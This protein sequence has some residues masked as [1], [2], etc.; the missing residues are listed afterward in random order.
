MAAASS[1]ERPKFV[2]RV[3]SFIPAGH[4]KALQQAFYNSAAAVLLVFVGG[5]ARAVYFVLEAFLKPLLWAVL[6]GTLLHPFKNSL[7]RV[8]RGWLKEL[9]D[10]GLPFA[11]GLLLVPIRVRKWGTTVTFRIRNAK[12]ILGY[13]QV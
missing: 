3:S 9:S 12:K 5:T 2:D 7:T 4:E 13:Y 6:C 1:E 11:V 8:V 10:S